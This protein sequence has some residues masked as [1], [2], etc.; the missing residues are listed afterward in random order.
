LLENRQKP[1]PAKSRPSCLRHWPG[2]LKN[3]FRGW[4]ILLYQQGSPYDVAHKHPVAEIA[5]RPS[6]IPRPPSSMNDL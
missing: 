4:Q 2:E 5:A 6:E 1:P 3:D